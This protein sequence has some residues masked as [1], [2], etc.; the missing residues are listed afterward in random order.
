MRNVRKIPLREGCQYILVD[1][2]DHLKFAEGQLTTL[3][4]LTATTSLNGE[5]SCKEGLLEC[6]LEE[7]NFR[8]PYFVDGKCLIP[9]TGTWLRLQAFDGISPEQAPLV[10]RFVQA[11]ADSS[12][13]VVEDSII[14]KLGGVDVDVKWPMYGVVDAVAGLS[15]SVLIHHNLSTHPLI[16]PQHL[17][18]QGTV[19][20]VTSVCAS[21]VHPGVY[22]HLEG[23]SLFWPRCAL[24]L[25]ETV[26]RG[27]CEGSVV[28]LG[29]HDAH[30]NWAPG[31]VP[32]VGSIAT[33]KGEFH[34]DIQG[35]LT[36]RVDIDHG[37]YAWRI[38]NMRK[39]VS[40]KD[41]TTPKDAMFVKSCVLAHNVVCVNASIKRGWVDVIVTMDAPKRTV[42]VPME[43]KAVRNN[44]KCALKLLEIAKCIPEQTQVQ[45]QTQ[46]QTQTQTGVKP[47]K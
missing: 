19:S 12:F 5:S 24:I 18:F 37:S 21:D 25:F 6:R 46:T 35:E 38:K 47:A 29:V 7:K 36:C 4:S 42:C 26:A 33:V 34:L 39:I 15:D 20:R 14:F 8:L 13:R 16:T 22:C 2:P 23:N 30:Q 3:E 28:Q 11:Y 10:G 9:S 40:L 1:L 44:F 31:M 17:M 27:I 41:V 43:M 45:I 32:F